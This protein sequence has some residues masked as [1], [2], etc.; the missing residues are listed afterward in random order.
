MTLEMLWTSTAK[1]LRKSTT[2]EQDNTKQ[3]QQQHREAA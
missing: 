2:A 1:E 3:R